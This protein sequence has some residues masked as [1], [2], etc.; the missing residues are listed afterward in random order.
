ML[1]AQ[2]LVAGSLPPLIP[3]LLEPLPWIILDLGITKRMFLVMARNVCFCIG[4]QA[5][6]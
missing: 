6:R 5:R 1:L 2:N 3:I 4:P